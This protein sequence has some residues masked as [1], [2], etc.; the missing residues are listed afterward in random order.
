ML[1]VQSVAVGTCNVDTE[2]LWLKL[3]N[4]DTK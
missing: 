3:S 4:I 2:D 1:H